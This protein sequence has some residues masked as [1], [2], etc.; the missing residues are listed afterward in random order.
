MA[1]QRGYPRYHHR[2]DASPKS[3]IE[4]KNQTLPAFSPVCS[5]QTGKAVCIVGE[6]LGRARQFRIVIE[7]EVTPS[8]TTVKRSKMVHVVYSHVGRSAFLECQVKSHEKMCEPCSTVSFVI[9]QHLPGGKITNVLDYRAT[10][11]RAKCLPQSLP[12]IHLLK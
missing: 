8:K 10:S 1:V 6:K 7:A 3:V 2:Q 12:F 4:I 11:S 5:N 9:S